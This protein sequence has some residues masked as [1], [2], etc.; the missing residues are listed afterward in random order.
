M[1]DHDPE[2]PQ[3]R[4]HRQQ[5]QARARQQ[6][7]QTQAAELKQRGQSQLRDRKTRQAAED[8]TGLEDNDPRAAGPGQ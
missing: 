7:L 4:T 3:D 2:S 6:E 5:R 1:V 8:D